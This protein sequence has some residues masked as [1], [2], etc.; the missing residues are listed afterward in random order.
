[1]DGGVSDV[2]ECSLRRGERTVFFSGTWGP[3]WLNSGTGVKNHHEDK[4]LLTPPRL[5]VRPGHCISPFL[6]FVSLSYI[7]AVALDRQPHSLSQVP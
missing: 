2:L 4:D 7:F 3:T 1:M 6:S 5:S